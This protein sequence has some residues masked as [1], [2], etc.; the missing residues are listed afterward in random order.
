MK[1]KIQNSFLRLKTYIEKE[2]FKGYDPFDG[3]NSKFFQTLPIVKENRFMRLAWIQLFKRNPI[4]LRRLVAVPK[5]YNPKALGLF[6][7][8]YSNLYKK[9]PKQEY[10]E[11]IIF[12]ADKLLKIQS[13]DYSG[14]AWGYN[15][16]WQARA[17]FQ[18]KNMPTVVATSFI[19]EALLSAYEIIRDEKYLKTAVSAQDFILKDLNRTYDKYGFFCFSYSPMYQTQVFNAGL[20][21]V[22]TLSLIYK[23][24]KKKFLLDE[25]KKV[26]RF[27]ANHQQKNG[28][29]AYGTLPFHQWIDN[30]HTGYNLEAI[31]I[32][33]DISGDNSFQE[34]LKLGMDYYLNTFFTRKGQS[35]YYNNKL[36]PID[37]HAPAQLLVT[38]KKMNKFDENKNLIDKVLSWTIDN[39]QDKKG[40]FYYQKKKYFTTEI[41]YMRW[42]NAWMFYAFS[43]Y[44]SE[45]IT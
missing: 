24:T 1:E 37:I 42:A 2:K 25:A 27:V 30:F 28:A 4:N 10:L 11:K 36:Y 39:M 45:Q 31:Q 17:F 22:K 13:K 20:L 5:E 12:L 38:L 41:S 18:P 44:S 23:Y 26:L 21:G 7:T 43:Y 16:D 14:A 3:L 9:N 15:F 32:Y 29:W 33:Q 19:V 8:G 6:L 35:K 34:H 40:Y